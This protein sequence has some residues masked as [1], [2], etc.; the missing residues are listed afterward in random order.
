MSFSTGIII[1]Y[2]SPKTGYQENIVITDSKIDLI[3]RDEKHRE[4]FDFYIDDNGKIKVF[5]NGFVDATSQAFSDFIDK[6]LMNI[7]N[8]YQKQDKMQMRM[9]MFHYIIEIMN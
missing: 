5:A 8:M 4:P 7:K 1:V 2:I 6:K 9:I 3:K